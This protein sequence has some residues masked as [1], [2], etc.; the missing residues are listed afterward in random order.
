[1]ENCYQASNQESI[2]VKRIYLSAESDISEYFVWQVIYMVAC[3]FFKKIIDSAPGAGC[4]NLYIQPHERKGNNESW[5]NSKENR[6]EYKQ[7]TIL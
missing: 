4:I 7:Y 5:R 6:N 3:Y 1:M 2:R